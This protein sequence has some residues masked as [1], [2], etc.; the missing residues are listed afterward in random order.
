MEI[1][2]MP[3]WEVCIFFFFRLA[4]GVVRAALEISFKLRPIFEKSIL[5]GF[6]EQWER[7]E[8]KWQSGWRA[9]GD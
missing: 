3:I 9:V 7:V 1:L 4:A 6:Q 5:L 2:M 8:K